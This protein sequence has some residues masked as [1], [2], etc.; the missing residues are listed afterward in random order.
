MKRYKS[1]PKRK[2]IFGTVLILYAI[3]GAPEKSRTPNLQIRS[4]ALYPIELR[5]LKSTND[6]NKF[7]DNLFLNTEIYCRGL[8][9]KS[10]RKNPDLKK[11]VQDDTLYKKSEGGPY[12]RKVVIA[13]NIAESSLTIKDYHML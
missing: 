7:K 11:N 8:D 9:G 1:V 2:F 13:T 10:T 6:S 12:G 4:L 3:H 5:A